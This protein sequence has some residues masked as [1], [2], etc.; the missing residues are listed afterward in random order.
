MK[1]GLR[2]AIHYKKWS[3]VDHPLWKVVCGWPSIIKRGLWL[4]QDNWQDTILIEEI[5]FIP[6][7]AIFA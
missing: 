6:T 7:V 1:S 3:A 4:I 2:L 5:I